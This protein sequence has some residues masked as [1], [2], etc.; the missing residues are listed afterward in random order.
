MYHTSLAVG[1]QVSIYTDFHKEVGYEVEAV[2]IEKIEN[3]DTFFLDEFVDANPTMSDKPN[4]LKEK[5]NE[6]LNAVFSGNIKEQRPAIQKFFQNVLKLRSNKLDDYNKIYKFIIE[7]RDKLYKKQL[8]GLHDEID[9]KFKRILRDIP[10]DYITRYFQQFKKKVNNTIF[11]YE[12]WK[13]EFIT[14]ETGYPV[15]HVAI[16]KIRIIIKNNYKDRDGYSELT[17]LTTYNGKVLRR[18]NK[19]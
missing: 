4:Q 5:R 14:D 19:I 18:R 7:Y 17:Y 16:K 2:L 3:G 13:V 9:S 11:K 15:S 10:V 1:K 12:K 8:L 6:Q